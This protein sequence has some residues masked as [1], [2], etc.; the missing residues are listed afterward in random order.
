MTYKELLEELNKLSP[1]QL[2]D[3]VTVY[4]RGEIE[5][6][7]VHMTGI[8]TQDDVLHAGHYF[9]IFNTDYPIGE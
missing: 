5:F 2:R 6:F 3:D 4:D 8:E 1:V 7:K 9:L